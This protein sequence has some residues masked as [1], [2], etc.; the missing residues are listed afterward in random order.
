MNGL[1]AATTAKMLQQRLDQIGRTLGLQLT[2]NPSKDPQVEDSDITVTRK[3][4]EIGSVQITMF[5]TYNATK[6]VGESFYFG[7]EQKTVE[8]AIID[9]FELGAK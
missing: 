2:Y 3:G 6:R 5:G 9:L 8:A 1:A 4:E 7:D